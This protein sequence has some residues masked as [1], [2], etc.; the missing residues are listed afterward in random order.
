LAPLIGVNFGPARALA[1]RSSW[2]SWGF[3][4]AGGVGGAQPVGL[5]AGLEDVGIEGD[6][7]HDG[8]DQAG[9][10]E[11]GAP[12]AEREVGPDRDGGSFLPLGDDLEQQLGA[13]VV[14]L[15][16]AQLVQLCR[17]L[18]RSF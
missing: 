9:V 7:V 3:G 14:D 2:F 10:G 11:D 13:A 17:Y 6:P 1:W 12:F 15:D 18:I 16:V 8:G 5:G 4:A